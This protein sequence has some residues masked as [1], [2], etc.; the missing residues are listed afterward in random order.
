M[1]SVPGKLPP[2]VAQTARDLVAARVRVVPDFPKPGI[3]FRDITP[4]LADHE[5]LSAALDLHIDAI[6]EFA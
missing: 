5:A 1:T 4:V 3:L 2:H 6:S